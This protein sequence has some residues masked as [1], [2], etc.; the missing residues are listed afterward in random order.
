MPALPLPGVD[1]SEVKVLA[2][3]IGAREAARRM[4]LNEDTV[5]AR[6]AREDWFSKRREAQA[7]LSPKGKAQLLKTATNYIA[8]NASNVP[9]LAD[10]MAGLGPDS[11]LK[12]AIAGNK[13]VSRLSEMDGDELLE[14]TTAQSAKHWAG[15]L[16]LAHGWQAEGRDG[17]Q[18][19]VNIAFLTVSGDAP[20]LREDDREGP[21]GVVVDT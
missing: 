13:V 5:C 19:V 8:S 6:A 11:K 21:S 16:A 12:L 3:A 1:W 9:S 15:N 14:P 10:V 18:T 2:I 17:A 20:P 4:G 7:M